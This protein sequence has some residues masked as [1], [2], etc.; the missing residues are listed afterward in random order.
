MSTLAALVRARTALGEAAVDWLHRLVGEWQLVAARSS[1]ACARRSARSLT[2][3]G[4]A[5]PGR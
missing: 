2:S 4:R 3:S 5:G 1:G